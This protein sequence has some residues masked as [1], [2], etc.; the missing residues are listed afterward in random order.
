MTIDELRTALE[1][2]PERFDHLEVMVI[3]GR[4]LCHA[5]ELIL[6]RAKARSDQYRHRPD[7]TPDRLA[8]KLRISAGVVGSTLWYEPPPDWRLVGPWPPEL[9]N[10]GVGPQ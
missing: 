10:L 7:I 8:R 6:D 5:S 1:A 4:G 9:A 2:L 3:A